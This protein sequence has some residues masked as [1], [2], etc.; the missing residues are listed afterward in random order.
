AGT[1]YY[2]VVVTGTCGNATSNAAG[3]LVNPLTTIGTQPT[4]ATYCQNGSATALTA[5]AT[6]T[7][8][9]TYQWYSNASNSNS[10]GTSLG[11]ANGAQTAFYTPATTAAGT[12]YYYVVVTGTCGNA[13]SNAAGITVTATPVAGTIGITSSS[14]STNPSMLCEVTSTHPANSATLTASG[15]TGTITWQQST[16]GSTWTTVTGSSNTPSITI[17]NLSQTTLYRVQVINGSCTTPVYSNI[18]PLQWIQALPPTNP[19]ATPPIICLGESSTLTADTGY[20]P[21]GITANQGDF[22]NGASD[23]KTWTVYKPDG[24]VDGNA[25]NASGDNSNGGWWAETNGPQKINANGI[26]YQSPDNKFAIVSG[27]FN[28]ILESP[29]F[30]FIGATSAVFSFSQAYNLTSGAS[31]KIEISTNGGTS[32]TTLET[33]TGPATFGTASGNT[34]TV[35]NYSIDL[36]N[37]LGMSNLRIRFKYQG[38]T[39]SA[40]ALDN[41][42]TPGANLPISYAWSGTILNTTIGVPVIATPQITGTSYYTLQTTIAGCP[43]G[44]VQVAVVT[45]PLPTLGGLSQAAVCSGSNGTINL[46]GLLPNTTSSIVYNI[47]GGSGVTVNNIASDASGNG[48]FTI[49][50]TSGQNGQTLTI[51]SI[52]GN[53]SNGKSCGASPNKSVTL[54]VNPLPTATVTGATT[55]CQNSAQSPVVSFNGATGTGAYTFTYTLNGGSNQ[56]ISGDPATITVP[57]STAGTFTYALVSVQ[58]SKGCV[59]PQIGSAT[60]T[61]NP[62]A[63]VAT[64]PANKLACP[65]GAIAFTVTASSAPAPSYS[66]EVNDGTGWSPA[67]TSD[68]ST[69]Q[70]TGTLTVSNI[71]AGNTKNGYLYRVNVIASA[72]CPVTTPDAKLT[73]RNI[74]YG[75]TNTDWNTASNWSDKAVPSQMSCDSVII[76]NVTNKPILSTGANGSV[77]HLVM[78]PGAKLT[79]TGNIMHIAGSIIDDNMA[80]DATAGTID[81]NGDKE[82]YNSNQRLIQTIAGHMFAT[83]YNNNSGRLQNLQISSPNNANVAPISALNDTL[84]ITGVLSFGNV[85]GVTL[86][87][88]NNI[89][90]VSDRSGTAQVADITN[91]NTNPGNK[92]NGWVEVERYININPAGS[93]YQA[94]EFLATPTKGQTVYQSWMEGGSKTIPGYGDLI[95]DPSGAG[96]GFDFASPY[97]SMKYYL[98]GS[99]PLNIQSPDWQGISN[100]GNQIYATSGYMLFVW[101]DRT[102]VPYTGTTNTRMRTKGDLIINGLTVP[103]SGTLFTSVGN[104]YASAIDMKK[105]IGASSVDEPFTTWQSASGG[106]YGFGY[107]VAHTKQGNDYVA[108]PGDGTPDNNV[109]SGQAF[110][111]QKLGGGSGSV[112]FNE[113]SKASGSSYATFIPAGVSAMPAQLR[114]NLY[115]IKSTG[116]TALVDGTLTQYDD[117]FSNDLDGTDALKVYNPGENFAIWSHG[118]GLIAEKR[119]IIKRDDTLFYKFTGAAAAK[120]RIEFLAKGMSANGLQGYLVDKYLQKS[121][122]LNME[123]ATRMDITIENNSGSKDPGRFFIIFKAAVVLPT[124]IVSIDANAQNDGILVNW[125]V[126]NENNMQRY[127]VEKS[128]D[129]V[130]FTNASSIDALNTGA[131]DYRWLDQHVLPGYNYYR[132][133]SVDRVGKIQYTTIVKVLIGNGQPSISIY[134]NPIT[135]GTINLH[136]NNMPAGKYGIR[137]MNQLG[138]VIVSKQVERSDGSSIES[139]KWDY[140]L[141]HGIY[142]LEVILPNKSEKEIKVIY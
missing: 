25:L 86:N 36:S 28:S 73:I 79:I 74:W 121:T 42:N 99:S 22:N 16:N 8:T 123:G 90:M 43:G 17:T 91:N 120:Y 56:T 49:P 117:S 1:T 15:T 4:G 46:T 135:D 118:K 97:P 122:P 94:W 23:N 72:S 40:W 101:G 21:V 105:V 60:V 18:I 80:I 109:Q 108:I 31:A 6:G 51:T 138:Q 61:I 127:E 57:T 93:H 100:T 54:T 70:N 116:A 110:F 69:D 12:T 59:N 77:N 2:Y 39:T 68:Y 85:S 125:K 88:G 11:S 140:N 63:T 142:R 96:G 137:L 27:N 131:N 14:N 114:S 45:N 130:H 53:N 136:L 64:P 30:S 29:V 95:S 124:T 128:Y 78:R 24:T 26:T 38:N 129:G 66:W 133:R 98:P 103:T 106:T 20:P 107:F 48:S 75:Y 67:N 44:Q 115:V 34:N 139:I 33:Y 9:L 111:V 92:F 62:Q 55:L 81:L 104:P 87:T 3:I 141:S 41:L 113:T 52:T 32:Y 119:G 5:A 76:L 37:Y 71:T 35:K 10:G 134:P 65:E 19:L 13:T 89:T 84:N 82:L 102:A 50:L 7:G 126:N 132:V 83:P 47:N 58:D 112:V